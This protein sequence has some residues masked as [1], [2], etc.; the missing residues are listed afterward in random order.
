M[1]LKSPSLKSKFS[2]LLIVSAIA[3]NLQ[4]AAQ[5]TETRRPEVKTPAPESGLQA[6]A[7][8]TGYQD[9]W[10]AGEEAWAHSGPFRLNS[11]DQYGKATHGYSEN[12]G[13]KSEY[14]RLYRKAFEEGYG[15]GYGTSQPSHVR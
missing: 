9:G 11:N 3:F 6:V 13:D 1:P 14:K 12:L 8:R 10:I 4:L 2:L 15:V 7:Y 5:S